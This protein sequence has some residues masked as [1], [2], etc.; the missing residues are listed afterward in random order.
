[1]LRPDRT[2]TH[3][4]ANRQT[5]TAFAIR[6][7]GLSK[8]SISQ[9]Y[10]YCKRK[11]QIVGKLGTVVSEKSLENLK[12]GRAKGVK[13]KSTK[14]EGGQTWR[15]LILEYGNTAAPAELAAPLGGTATWKQVVVAAAYRH[16]AAGNAPI[17]KELMQRSEP[18]PLTHLDLSKLNAEQLER[19][20]NGEDPAIVLATSSASG[21][22]T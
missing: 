3:W 21:V 17:L 14:A 22:G 9:N 10:P 1:M 5:K 19:I 2:L 18:Q 15:D 20:A 16:A 6:S 12:K 7:L 8:I 11:S 13:R 4:G